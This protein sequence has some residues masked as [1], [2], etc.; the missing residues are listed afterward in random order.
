[1]PKL[2]KRAVLEA[3]IP[4]LDFTV[5]ALTGASRAIVRG[6]FDHGCVTLN[7]APCGEAG[8]PG[9]RG[10]VVAVTW[11]PSQ[12]YRERAQPWVSTKFR[13]AF[14]DAHLIVVE[15]VAGILTVETNR[16]G[17][18]TLVDDVAR[19]LSRG[20]RITRRAFVVHRLDRDTSGVLVF[21]KTPRMAEALIEQFKDRK[22]E[23][24]YAAIV[25]RQLST[26]AGTFRSFLTTSKDLREFS[27]TAPG[28][29]KLAVTHFV[30]DTRFADATFVRVNLETG[31]R[32]QIR[33]HFAEAG[34][35]VL[36]DDRYAPERAA[37]P[38]WHAPRLALHAR[39]LGF[40]HPATRRPV[41]VTSE[42]PAPFVAF[43]QHA[44]R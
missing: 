41:R 13:V 11:D 10:D 43:L 15:K 39:T 8:R 22:P 21:G 20:P 37:H 26:D 30:V 7:G 12:R 44:P 18:D 17:D 16:G 36:G 1:M 24:E 28:V 40:T 2:T 6:L 5:Q 29:G 25:A 19:Y 23:R 9:A 34:H 31:R 14:E 38:L 32:N 42:L 35:P 27:T 4:R 3:A 33:V